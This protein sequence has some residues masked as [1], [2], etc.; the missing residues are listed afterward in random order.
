[1]PLLARPGR[2]ARALAIA[3]P[4]T[5]AGLGAQG[6]RATVVLPGYRGVVVLDT[7]GLTR[8]VP[9]TTGALFAAVRG[10]LDSLRIPVAL[11]DSARG[12]L[13]NLEWTGAR[14][15]AGQPMARW[16]DCGIGP[17]GPTANAYRIHLALLATIVAGGGR[18][19]VHVAL[20]AGAQAF[21]GPLGDPIACQSTGRLEELLLAAAEARRPAP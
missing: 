8:A 6:P 12:L 19:T 10:A 1:M 18:P 14:R 20:A 15:F 7:V 4:L 9:G 5:A 13:G 17:S 3:L 21:S 16:I 2:V 11:A